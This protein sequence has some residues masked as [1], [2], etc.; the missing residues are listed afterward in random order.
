MGNREKTEDVCLLFVLKD[1]NE[2]KVLTKCCYTIKSIT[3][4]AYN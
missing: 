4:V 3:F 1:L 2:I